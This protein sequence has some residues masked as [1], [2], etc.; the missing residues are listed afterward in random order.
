M[1]VLN[2]NMGVDIP[3]YDDLDNKPSINGVVLEGNKTTEDL[4][5]EGD[6]Y[7]LGQGMKFESGTCYL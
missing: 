1:I 5:I 2:E 7:D 4:K 6:L 3:N